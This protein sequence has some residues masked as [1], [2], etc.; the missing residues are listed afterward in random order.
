[1]RFGSHLKTALLTLA[2]LGPGSA[3]AQLP[4]VS[5]HSLAK[6]AQ[7]TAADVLAR[8]LL[9]RDNLELIR[10]FMG[11][12]PAPAPLL[13]AN[14]VS[15]MEVFFSA[16]NVGR[17]V[18]RLAFEQLRVELVRGPP[19]LPEGEVSYFQLFNAVEGTRGL[20]LKVKESLGITEAVAEKVQPA[21]TTNAELFNAMLETGALLNRLLER[22]T[23]A[24]DTYLVLT[25]TIHQ[26]M[27]LHLAQ[28]RRMMPKEP[29][30]VPNKM[31]EDVFKKLRSCFALLRKIAESQN[32]PMLS[33]EPR[34]T[35][36]VVPDDMFDL[37][38]VL[39]AELDRL[40][41]KA[42]MKRKE[43]PPYVPD[44]KFPAHVYQR[45]RL[46]EQLLE[47]LVSAQA[48]KR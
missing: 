18:S 28:T 24:S 21:A 22:Q 9:V 13:R 4:P 39:I 35:R 19:K 6:P 48:K 40:T 45:A 37:V 5:G 10:K 32:L 36:A 34:Q 33:F 31:P 41:T 27:Q 29:K 20:V 42:G 8:L 16:L 25:V 2:I 1:M 7:I 43:M 47:N 11:R 23:Q 46:L 26:T 17:R 15:K 30:F 44:K 3:Q 14:N 38:V 12:H